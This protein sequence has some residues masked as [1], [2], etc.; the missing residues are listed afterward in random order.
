MQANPKKR[1]GKYIIFLGEKLGFG[2]FSEVF[3]GIDEDTKEEVAVKVVN[4][5]KII[6]DEYTKNAFYSEIQ[7]NKKLKSVNI[8]KFY[9]VHETANNFYIVLELAQGGTLRSTLRKMG[10]LD[11]KRTMKY[12][13][14]ILNG[15]G[16]LAKNGITHRDLKP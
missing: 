7:I 12:L 15:F 9:D 16:E 13:I 3:K 4:K 11:E 14:Q 10:R 5:A 8:I 1:I 6:E 2:A